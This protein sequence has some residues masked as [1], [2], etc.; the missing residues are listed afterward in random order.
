MIMKKNYRSMKTLASVCFLLLAFVAAMAQEQTVTGKISDATGTGMPGV[1]VLKKGTT[2]G[3]TTDA[4][5]NYSI[6]ATPGDILVISFIGYQSKEITVGTQT[7][8]NIPLD[9]DI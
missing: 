1:N 9:E 2:I 6:N 4:D 5:G 3:T 8:I 7:T